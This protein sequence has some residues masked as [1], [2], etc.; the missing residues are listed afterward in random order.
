[1]NDTI[2][3]QL[4][5][6]ARELITSG[7]TR[8]QALEAFHRKFIVIALEMAGGSVTRASARIGVHRNTLTNVRRTLIG[9]TQIAIIRRN[10]SRDRRR[11]GRR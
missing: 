4:D 1:M 3:S 8:D 7:I 5:L 11:Q 2:D 10:A 9:D 6:I